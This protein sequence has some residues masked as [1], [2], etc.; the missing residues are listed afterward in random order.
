MQIQASTPE[1]Y[2]NK[3][4]YDRRE[5]ITNLRRILKDKLP[6]G[7]EEQ[8]SYGMI[9]YVVPH[10]VYPK[11]YHVNPQQP[12]PFI[13]IASQK[14][15]IAIYHMALYA[16]KELLDWFKKEYSEQSKTRLDMGKSCIRFKNIDAI[17]YDL[18]AELATKISAEEWIRQ[19]ESSVKR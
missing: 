9:G 16:D 19:Y 6:E 10:S 8:I 4:P 13:S 5:V 12:L 14:N 18:I 2:I 15:Y 7:F 1:D 11:G 3:L 17:P